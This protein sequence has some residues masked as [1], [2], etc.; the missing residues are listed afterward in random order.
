[1]HFKLELIR[2][3]PPNP[4]SSASHSSDLRCR[5]FPNWSPPMSRSR[6]IVAVV[7]LGAFAPALRAQTSYPMLS[8]VEPTAVRRGT[9][10]E[11]AI[12]GTGSFAG[13]WQLLCEGPGLEGEVIGG[14][15]EKT[16]EDAAA[17]EMRK[18]T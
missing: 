2:A 8:R 7:A 3:N 18:P 10:V 5:S 6:L 16:K 1:M 13:A 12:A 4:R 15:A 11:I 14:D 17:K 9:T